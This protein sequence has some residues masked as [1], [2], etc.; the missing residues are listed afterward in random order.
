MAPKEHIGDAVTPTTLPALLA[1]RAEAS[2]EDPF[3]R[4]GDESVSY[5]QMRARAEQAAASLATAGVGRGDRVA[6][7]LPNCLEFLDI[8]FGAALLGAAFV[9]VNMGL[10]GD[11]LRYVIEHSEPRV[12]VADESVVPALSAA[13]PDGGAPVLCFVR[14]AASP[15][16]PSLTEF[17]A[18][19]Y[20]VPRLPAV[21]SADLASILYTSGTTGPPK[22]VLN[23]HNAYST[24][25]YEF[26]HRYVRVRDDDVLYTSLP[27][28]H[29]N[30][31]M[32]TTCGSLLS[33]R[34]MV[35]AP[36]FS[37]SGFL[38]DL[39]RTGATV[40]NYIGAMLT[41]IAKQPARTDD[42]EHRVRL[43]VGGAAPEP[44]WPA[45]EKRFGLRILEIYG[46]TETATF[47]LGNPPDDIR[48]GKL[49]LPTSWAEVRVV[50]SDGTEA[51][52]GEPG[53]IVIRSKRPH[54]LFRGYFKDSAATEAAMNDGWFRS[55]DRGRRDPD[56][57][58]VY[59]DRLKDSIRRRGENISSY[60][61]EQVVN[62]HPAVAE[63]AAI[64]VPSPLGEEDVMIVIVL[65]PGSGE[66]DPAELVA[67]CGEHM[68]PFM[69]PRYVRYVDQLPKTATER[70]Q[71]Y[72][73]REVGIEG[74]WDREAMPAAR[75]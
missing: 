61:V 35:L 19:S 56:G 64:G 62:S 12:I 63:S 75:T 71:K 49:G 41:M 65:K 50:R 15:G 74:S 30:A 26:M 10:K 55:G 59:L 45:F 28:F 36:R 34:P 8:W 37:A 58:F 7:M 38:D 31:Q 39:R 27:L 11:G 67:F 54:I 2:P 68:A 48:V 4:F 21:S 22:G 43:A 47:C 40:F 51:A 42:A 70:V 23:C 17:L 16:W 24:A 32:L 6:I 3:V 5:G 25:A 46:L 33:G 29:V 73:L 66:L 44:L 9:P 1:G 69:V 52:D 14:G 13:L 60:E 57:Y 18:G 20:A 72:V 53:E